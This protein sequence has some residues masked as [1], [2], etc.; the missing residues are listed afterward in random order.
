[1]TERA[2]GVPGRPRPWLPAR[3]WRGLPGAGLPPVVVGV[4][5]IPTMISREEAAYLRWL[6]SAAWDGSGSIVEFGP[7]LGGSTWCLA[8]GMVAN[9]RR[10]GAPRLHVVDNFKWRP[11]MSDRAPLRLRTGESFRA[12]FEANLAPMRELVVVHEARLPDDR[13]SDLEFEAPV[14]DPAEDLPIV[15]GTDFGEDV[16][17]LFV[18]GAKSWRAIAHLLR[19]M[20]PW[21]RPGA[22]LAFQDH[23]S[24]A[25]FWVPMCIAWL[26]ERLPGVLVPV[27]VTA[28]NTTTFRLER[29]LDEEVLGA[30][31]PTID[32]VPLAD[33][34]RWLAAAADELRAV[35]AADGARVVEVS[36]VTFRGVKGD[37]VGARR[38]FERLD[39]RWSVGANLGDLEQARAW[40][41][42]WTGETPP[43]SARVRVIAAY[44]AASRHVR[45]LLGRARR[46]TAGRPVFRTRRP[47]DRPG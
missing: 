35:G 3:R 36:A 39:A 16:R 47:D 20:A 5:P 24:W 1:M 34:L 33:G 4:E 6:T 14:R 44:R 29:R 22:I 42:R 19:E 45:R 23:R 38:L 43:P 27:H 10:H 31:P 17:I 9:P 7:W 28:F 13:S 25:S 40:L 41:A 30:L 21:M 12:A 18:D 26:Q 37:W 11:F 2:L 46:L 15:R 32:E 8:S